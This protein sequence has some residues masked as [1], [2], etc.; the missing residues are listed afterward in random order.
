MTACCAFS[1]QRVT[2]TGAGSKTPY[3]QQWQLSWRR[4]LGT[5]SA[6]RS[7]RHHSAS[8][9]CSPNGQPSLLSA[10]GLSLTRIFATKRQK[11]SRAALC[12]LQDR[13][14][15]AHSQGGVG[16]TTGWLFGFPSAYTACTTCTLS[17]GCCWGCSQLGACDGSGYIHG[18]LPQACRAARVLRDWVSAVV[19]GM[20]SCGSWR[21]I[22][23]QCAALFRRARLLLLIDAWGDKQMRSALVHF[24]SFKL[25]Q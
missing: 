21:R 15:D 14:Q 4:R 19:R 17:L 13:T 11:H 23:C 1:Q 5:S 10:P 8:V 7:S 3:E 24:D 12:S 6:S 2:G 22:S 9:T 18:H 16:F 20:S 25:L